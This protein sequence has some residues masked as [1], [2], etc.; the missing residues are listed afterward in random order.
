MSTSRN[1][2]KEMLTVNMQLF[3]NKDFYMETRLCNIFKTTNA[4]FNI[5]QKNGQKFYKTKN[6]ESAQ[7]K[8]G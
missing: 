2:Y 7:L 1:I 8:V 6:L 3:A 5:S 4:Q